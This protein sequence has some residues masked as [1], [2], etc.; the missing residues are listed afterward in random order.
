MALTTNLTQSIEQYKLNRDDIDDERLAKCWPLQDCGKC[1]KTDA[2]CGWCPFS[3][4]CVPLPSNAHLLSPISNKH[5][6]PMPWQERYELRTSTFG[7]NCST[8][9]LLAALITF[10]SSV[11]G[12]VVLYGLVKLVKL[13]MKARGGWEIVIQDEQGPPR[14]ERV[15][16]RKQ[17]GWGEWWREKVHG[18]GNIEIVGENRPL[19]G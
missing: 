6:C 10:A 4:T 12:L 3:Q 2:D 5:I 8:T 19:L 18:E 17:K 9:T 13:L 15:W 16:V 1:L 7:C 11:L 14:V